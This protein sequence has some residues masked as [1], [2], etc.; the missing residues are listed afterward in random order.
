MPEPT[1]QPGDGSVPFVDGVTTAPAPMVAVPLDPKVKSAKRMVVGFGTLLYTA[2]VLWCGFLLAVLP[3]PTGQLQQ[4]KQLAP[5][6]SLIGGAGFVL[7]GI[8]LLRR[9]ARADVP[10]STRQR[11][12]VKMLLTILPAVILSV[13]VPVLTSR[14]PSLSLDIDPSSPQ[15]LIAPVAVKISAQRAA[16]TLRNLGLRPVQYEWD[17]NGDGKKDDDTVIP[18]VTAV[19][20]RPGNY[21]AAVRIT[22]DDGQFRKVTRR[23]VIPLAVFSVSPDEPIVDKP[24]K[25]SVAD[26]VT[27]TKQIKEIQW[28]FDGDGK[29]D[30]S[31][32]NPEILHT[33]F[34]VGSYP[35]S[36]VILLLNADK[37]QTQQ[38]YKRTIVV[39]EAPP[40]PFPVTVST[41]PKNLIGPAP[42]G[43]LFSVDTKE[44]V[45]EIAWDF[46]DGK[47]DRGV[48]LTR[49]AHSFDRPGLFSVVTGVRSLS[50]SL[51]EVTTV[52]QV[53]ETL[54]MQDLSFDGSPDVKAGAITG[55]APLNIQLTPKTSLP[56]IQFSWEGPEA[57]EF[58]VTDQTVQ[59]VYR[60]EGTY[61][62][63]LLAQGPEGKALRVPIKINVQPPAAEPVIN[64]RP[65]GGTAP[66][67][68]IF[69][70]S[71]TF[72][73]PD[74]PV[75]GYKWLFGDEHSN[76]NTG[77]LGAG[78]VE[79]TYVNPGEYTATLTIVMTSGKQ[80]NAKKTIV[81]RRPTLAACLT[82]SRVTV[83]QGK[84]VE[85]DSSCTTGTP[86]AIAWDVRNTDQPN[87]IVSQSPDSVYVHVFDAPGTYTVTL[88]VTDASG[89][90]DSK[91]ITITVTP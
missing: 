52:V 17:T 80:Y 88:A 5:L 34:A 44:P 50:G 43:I 11:S 46:G 14:E 29:A 57:S 40:L 28:D 35:V 71:D 42:F 15:D 32:Q 58:Q 66:L 91:S 54:Q 9:I 82:A 39:K 65:E 84:G 24:V 76:Q 21:I 62:L 2:Y 1:P 38:T 36:A 69:D 3:S 37:S 47:Q 4:L 90:Q 61:T 67:H 6:T 18:A 78:R 81:V 77:E 72:I 79:H 12:F 7:V 55:E 85:F 56:L 19:Y 64:V 49:I 45:K 33:Y 83:Q 48:N 23:I 10:I 59:A 73:P 70:A 16:D 31:T 30:E 63:T 26:L 20:P 25:F 89:A 87:I 68:V 53:A 86:T 13:I 74:Q 22:L 41:E 75:A 27:D 51:A 8:F 60:E